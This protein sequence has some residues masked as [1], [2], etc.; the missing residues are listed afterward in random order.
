MMLRKRSFAAL[1]M[2]EWRALRMTGREVL[3]MTIKG[4]QDNRFCCLP[5]AGVTWFLF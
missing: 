5:K 1:R 2:T 4:A 3:R